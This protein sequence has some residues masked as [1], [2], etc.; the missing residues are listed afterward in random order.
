MR[1]FH[2]CFPIALVVFVVS[3]LFVCEVG[4]DVEEAATLAH[5]FSELLHHDY[6]VE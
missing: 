6:K 1:S 3:E 2:Y 4:G 5:Y